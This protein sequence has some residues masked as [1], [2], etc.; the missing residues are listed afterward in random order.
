MRLLKNILTLPV[1]LSS[2]F[3]IAS[4]AIFVTPPQ[5]QRKP[6]D[7]IAPIVEVIHAEIK[8]HNINIKAHGLIRPVGNKIDLIPQVSGKLISYHPNFK[9]G[10]LIAK[11]E[12]IAQ[13]ETVDYEMALRDAKAELQIANAALILEKGQQRLAQKNFELS[14]NQTSSEVNTLLALRKPQLTTSLAQVQLAKNSIDKARLALERTKLTYPFETKMVETNSEIG[15][16]VLTGSSIGTVIR[17]DHLWLELRV[18]AKYLP[19]IHKKSSAQQGSYVK[20]SSGG[21]PYEGRVVALRPEV[22][23][24]TRMAGV[25]VE[26]D[27]TQ[28]PASSSLLINS[29]LSATIAA[30]TIDGIKIPRSALVGENKIY[31]VDEL[32]KLQVRSVKVLWELN[33]FVLIAAGLG[34]KELIVINQVHSILPNSK[35][36]TKHDSGTFGNIKGNEHE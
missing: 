19:R 18:L 33:D 11:D 15:A 8:S 22:G 21:V 17:T 9:P 25:I 5:S 34:A 16:V 24:T 10:G 2:V 12:V 6:V 7:Y 14:D 30:G 35:V 29:H 13:I 32:S 20:F 3:I 31:I 26:L 4:Y 36:T 28:E 27:S 23:E 1:I